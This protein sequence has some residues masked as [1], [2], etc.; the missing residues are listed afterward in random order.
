MLPGFFILFVLLNGI[1]NIMN[2]LHDG[3]G[4]DCIVLITCFL[5]CFFSVVDEGYT[6]NSIFCGGYN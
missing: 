5:F 3:S 1:V 6:G 2:V 4:H